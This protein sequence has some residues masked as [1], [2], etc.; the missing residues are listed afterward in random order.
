MLM[1]GQYDTLEAQAKTYRNVDARFAGGYPKLFYF[2]AALGAFHGRPCGCVPVFTSIITFAEKDGAIQAW[3]KAKP[4]S[5]TAAIAMA[6]LWTDYGWDAR[7]HDFADKVPPED[8]AVF[9]DRV[10]KAVTY[11]QA[12]DP[13][14][15]AEICDRL[16]QA[17]SALD[18]DNGGIVLGETYRA[19][20]ATFPTYYP[21]Y[22]TMTN[23]LQR[24]WFGA[25]LELGQYLQSL[26]TENGDAGLIGYS[27]AAELLSAYNRSDDVFKKFGVDWPTLKH[28]LMLREQRYG[29][30]N[31]LRNVELRLATGAADRAYAGDLARQIGDKWDPTIWSGWNG[32]AAAAAWATAGR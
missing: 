26:A 9:Q 23:Y 32:F 10:A 21:Y 19:A 20:I 30:S 2:Y 28:A 14:A 3:M 7:G 6:R 16:L 24:R 15:D 17:T 25:P 22:K 1:Q 5:M 11:L 31:Q 18:R 8:M 29:S 4:A 12:L 27:F 13:K